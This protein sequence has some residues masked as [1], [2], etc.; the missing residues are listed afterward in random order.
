MINSFIRNVSAPERPK[1]SSINL[2]MPPKSKKPKN[3]P[4][5]K[6]SMKTKKGGA[7]KSK[8]GGKNSMKNIE[9]L[10]LKGLSTGVGVAQDIGRVGM[11]V[12]RSVGKDALSVGRM[13]V[14]DVES[15]GRMGVRDV[16]SVGRMG[17]RDV[18]SVGKRGVKMLTMKRGKSKRGTRDKKGKKGK[19]KKNSYRAFLSK[20]LKEVKRAHP[21]WPQSKVFK[22]AVKGWKSSK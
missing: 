2:P 17:V 4:R 8:C 19:S 11:S 3:I 1:P 15:V 20:R 7:R 12:G 13:G 6:P 10:P 18:E 21:S 9:E 14:R 22:E 5:C 16:E